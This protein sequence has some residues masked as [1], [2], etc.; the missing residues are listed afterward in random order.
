MKYWILFLSIVLFGHDSPYSL[1]KFKNILDISKLQAP[2]SSYDSLYSV[3]YGKFSYYSNKYFFLQDKQYMTFFMCGKKNRSE[4]RF[5]KDWKTDTKNLKILKAKIK[6]FPLNEKREFTFLQIHADSTLENSINKPLL[7]IVWRKEFHSLK[8]HLWAVVR[9]DD[10]IRGKYA[11]FD[12]GVMP[13][14]FFSIKITVGFSKLSLWIDDKQILD[15]FDIGYWKKYYN[16]FKAGVY[17]Q[18]EGCAKVLFDKLKINY[19]GK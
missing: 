13:E 7:R 5:E 2:S 8:G 1:R 4:L 15:N 9:L 18:D 14:E 17:L 11:K 19:K 12:L 10:T 16:Y 6:L 3:K